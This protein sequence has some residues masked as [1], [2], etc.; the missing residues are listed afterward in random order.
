ME[1]AYSN[2]KK[3][4]RYSMFSTYDLQYVMQSDITNG[5]PS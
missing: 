5:K 4:G 3:T 2:M 1:K